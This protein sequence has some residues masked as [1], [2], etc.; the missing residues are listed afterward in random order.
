MIKSKTYNIVGNQIQASEL[1]Y[2]TIYV[3]KKDGIQQDL[4]GSDPN[5]SYS[6]EQ[7]LGRISFFTSGEKAF[8]IYKESSPIVGEVIGVCIPPS[9]TS[10]IMPIGQVGIPY[11]YSV[12]LLG[13]L[14]RLLENIVKPAWAT[15]AMN[16]LTSVKVTGTPDTET[17]ETV[18]FDISNGCGVASFNRSFAVVTDVINF[19]VFSYLFSSIQSVTGLDYLILSGSYPTSGT[20]QIQ[21]IHTGYT[22]TIEVVVD[23]IAFPL[24]L[25]IRRNGALLQTISVPTNGTYTFSSQTYLSTDIIEISLTT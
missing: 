25:R 23:N 11:N 3:V 15:V 17:T 19:N 16:G 1:A 24:K 14:P 4:Y 6:Y 21:G 7:A 12:L 18:S 13:S 5:R 2:T 9:I 8:V 10:S 22:G 20:V